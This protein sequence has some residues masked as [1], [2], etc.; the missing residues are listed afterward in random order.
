MKKIL[1]IGLFI[2][3]ITASCF[4]SSAFAQIDIS[5][6]TESDSIETRINNLLGKFNDAQNILI[7]SKDPKDRAAAK[8]LKLIKREV[9]R[10]I[11]SVP[12]T[13]CFDKVKTAMDDFYKLVSKLGQGI[14]CGPPIIPPFLQVANPPISPDCAL[15]P[16]D[17]VPDQID[18]GFSESLGAYDTARDIF[19]IDSNSNE[20]PDA[21][22]GDLG[23]SNL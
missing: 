1:F 19:H 20:I 11:N 9:I 4:T 16:E 10:A 14:A 12:S 3:M 2:F 17:V 15:P 7:K 21:C 5:T 23:S 22:E 18:P 13:K 6:T 8:K